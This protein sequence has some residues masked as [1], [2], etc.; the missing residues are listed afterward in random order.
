MLPSTVIRMRG[1]VPTHRLSLIFDFFEQKKNIFLPPLKT[2]SSLVIVWNLKFVWFTQTK[3]E[4]FHSD[5]LHGLINQ[6]SLLRLDS[7]IFNS[8]AMIQQRRSCADEQ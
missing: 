3:N 1:S 7:F 4:S 8:I 2:I 5:S 6:L